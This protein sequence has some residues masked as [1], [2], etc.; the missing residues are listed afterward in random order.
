[1]TGRYVRVLFVTLTVLALAGSSEAARRSSL[2]GNLL[3]PDQDDIFFFPQLVTKHARMATFDFGTSDTEGSAGLVFGNESVTLGAFTHRSDFLGALPDAFLQR[4]DVD[5][6]SQ[7]GAIDV[8]GIGPDALNWID[9]LAGFNVG[10]MPLG[11]RFSIGRNNNDPPDPMTGA[12]EADVTAVNAIVGMTFDQFDSDVAIEGAYA[13]ARELAAMVETETS[14]FHFGVGFRRRSGEESD[15][16]G[17]GW[18]GLFSWSSGDIDV[19]TGTM[20]ASAGDLRQID[21]VF[22]AGPTYHPN[23]RTNVAMYG[24][25]EYQQQRQET[26]ITGGAN[27]LT[28]TRITIPGWNIAG[29]FEVA[30]WMQFRAGVRSSFLFLE[31]RNETS[32]MTP[33]DLRTKTNDLDFRWTTGV[34]MNFGGFQI[35]GFLDPQV[36][37]SGTDLLGETTSGDLFALVSGTYRF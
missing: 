21:V 24:T 25:F 30:S 20:T 15:E 11:V 4:G 8:F 14:P 9:V 22:G 33:S 19:T 26:P 3:I 6:I 10:E 29:E 17:L 23:D 1:M 37:T 2:S 32:G 18:L 31:D 34:G 27:T 35:D 16:I 36:I 28:N 7:E 13:S 12:I 5:N